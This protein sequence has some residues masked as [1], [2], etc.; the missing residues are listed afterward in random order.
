MEKELTL[1]AEEPLANRSPS[2]AC[3]KDW[4][5]RVATSCLSFSAFLMR[6]GPAGWGQG[7][8]WLMA[9]GMEVCLEG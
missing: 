7:F 3:E 9:Q 6:S 4:L 2:L 1:F 8:K 5:T